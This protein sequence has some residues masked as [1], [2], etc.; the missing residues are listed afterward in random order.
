MRLPSLRKF[1]SYCSHVFPKIV[2]AAGSVQIEAAFLQLDATF[3]SD[4]LVFCTRYCRMR[5]NYFPETQSFNSGNYYV[6]L[7]K[8]GCALSLPYIHCST[9]HIRWIFLVSSHAALQYFM[10]AYLNMPCYIQYHT[11]VSI[12]TDGVFYNVEEAVLP[13]LC[14]QKTKTRKRPLALTGSLLFG[15]SKKWRHLVSTNWYT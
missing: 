10:F 9:I 5:L 8:R 11:T 1:D 15:L 12:T 14:K 6:S 4:G 13:V 2:M 7:V 3:E